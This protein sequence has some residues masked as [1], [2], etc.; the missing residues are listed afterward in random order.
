MDSPIVQLMQTYLQPTGGPGS[1]DQKSLDRGRM[2]SRCRHGIAPGR[3][4]ERYQ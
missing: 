4:E 1:L 2:S 3:S